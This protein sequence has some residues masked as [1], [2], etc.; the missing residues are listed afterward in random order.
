M[1]SAV[2]ALCDLATDRP[3]VV[4]LAAIGAEIVPAAVGIF[5]HDAIGGADEARFVLLVVPRHRKSQY[6]DGVA[7]DDI[8]ED[9]TIVHMAR[10]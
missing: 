6:V 2:L 4:N 8:L 5:G 3:A 10:R 9:R 1:N 7:F